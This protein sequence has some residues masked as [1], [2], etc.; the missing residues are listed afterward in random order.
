M[1]TLYFDCFAGASG[2]MILGALV[3]AGVPPQALTEQLALLRVRG[4]EIDFVTVVR[5]GISATHARVHTAHEHHHRH[6]S[7]ILKIISDSR[8]S[9]GVK[10]RA[11]QIFSRLA[12][13]EAKVH[14]EPIETIHFHEVGAL[15]AIVD[16]VGAAICFEVLGIERFVCSPLHLGSGTVDMDHGRFPVPPPAVAELLKGAPVYS[17]E[18]SGELVT[19][20]GA[21]IITTV[22]NEFGPI[23]KMSITQT[24]Y[25]AGTRE[26]KGFPN[27]LR[28]LIGDDGTTDSVE[29]LWMMETNVDDLSPQVFGHVMERAFELGALDCYLTAVQMKKNRPGVL[30]SIL[31]RDHER[32]RLSEMVFAETTTLGLRSYA[33][34]RQVL[35]RESVRVETPYGP[36]DVKV[37]RMNGRVVNQMP[38]YEQCREAARLANVPLRTVQEQAHAAFAVQQAS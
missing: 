3:A 28:V 7:D 26:Y 9:A 31:C 30:L 5:S 19:P 1:K 34:E 12:A 8:L 37:A 20:T 17:T 23:P 11:A 27:A 29:T 4:F 14:N 2:D 25:G 32:E 36:I 35:E 21:A 15:D 16:V 22:C 33:V 38:E 6:L 18:I 24:G 13:A 10:E